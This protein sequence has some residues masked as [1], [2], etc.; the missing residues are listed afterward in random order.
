LWLS[1]LANIPGPFWNRISRLPLLYH[2]YRFERSEY[3]HSLIETYGS[4]VVIAPNQ[5]HT[6]DEA[7]MKV[8]YD[9]Q[10]IKTRFYRGMGSWKGIFVTL[11]F[12]DYKSAAPTRNNLILCFQNKNLDLLQEAVAGHVK[13]FVRALQSMAH[14]R[15]D[16]DGAIWFRL[17]ALDVVTDVLWGESSELLTSVDDRTPVFLQRFNAFSK[18]NAMKSSIPGFDLYVRLFGTKRWST[19]RSDCNDI[20]TTAHEAL[21]RWETR[22]KR[23]GR[24]V[25]SML[26]EMECNDKTGGQHIPNAHIPA[27]MVEMM[28]AGSSTTSLTAA[29]TCR[30]LTRNQSAQE[31]LREE[32]FRA[33]PD[34]EQILP[35]DVQNL[36]YLDAVIR[37]T[38]RLWPAIP[39]PLERYLANPVT[40][41]GHYIPK[42]VVASTAAFDQGRLEDVYPDHNTWNPD[43]W[44]TATPR[45]KLNWIPFGYGSR[46]CPGSNL[47]IGE[48]KYAIAVIFRLLRAVDNSAHKDMDEIKLMDVFAAGPRSG[49]CWLRFEN[50]PDKI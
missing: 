35:R 15:Q 17:L 29:L 4:V 24:D 18:Y 5:I 28:A 8:I 38:M 12:P 47:A 34:R 37:E 16:L 23:H 39:G 14:Q 6:T 22:D 45:M 36:P 13:K 43:R 19:L 41:N 1:P 40:V 42:G 21:R 10:S 9:R 2:T 50:A 7:A 30:L 44:L 46:S 3:A 25:L 31:K 27:Y 32:L 49:T 33:F 26:K 11:G 20:D 48:I